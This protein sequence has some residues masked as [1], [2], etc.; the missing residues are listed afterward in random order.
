M[1]HHPQVDSNQEQDTDDLQESSHRGIPLRTER[2]YAGSTFMQYE[3]HESRTSP[4]K[5][6]TPPILFSNSR[7]HKS[8]STRGEC[9][10]PLLRAS[11]RRARE[12]T[13]KASCMITRQR[14]AESCASRRFTDT[15]TFPDRYRR[16]SC[17]QQY[18]PHEYS[19]GESE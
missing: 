7:L 16:L 3:G 2:D 19:H 9:E 8:F 12:R 5:F 4:P 17:N 11:R 14:R 13:R 1:P 6:A 15:C 18:Q 10:Y